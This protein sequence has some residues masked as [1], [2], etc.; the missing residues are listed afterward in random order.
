MSSKSWKCRL[1]FH[2]YD[3]EIFTGETANARYCP[4]Q[5]EGCDREVV[6]IAGFDYVRVYPNPNA[7]DCCDSVCSFCRP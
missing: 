7:N 5:R 6:L 4:C 1:D 2:D 3:P